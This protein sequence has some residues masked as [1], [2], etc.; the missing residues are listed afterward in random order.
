MSLFQL[1]P[2]RTNVTSPS[3]GLGPQVVADIDAIEVRPVAFKWKGKLH[4]IKP[5]STK[6]YLKVTEVF[7]KMDALGKTSNY[8]VEQ[9]VDVY[10]ELIMTLCNTIKREDI[11]EMSQAQVGAL[12]QLVIDH[13][14]GR[15]AQDEK[16]KTL[17][18]TQ[19]P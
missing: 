7:G 11:L 10:A 6:E 8:T 4:T 19:V 17:A 9:L 1:R 2:A 12:L 14:T 16:K 13:V 15:V 3:D 18:Q 5:V